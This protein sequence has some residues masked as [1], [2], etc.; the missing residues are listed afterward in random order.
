MLYFRHVASIRTEQI[1]IE[2]RVHLFY[3]AHETRCSSDQD[4]FPCVVFW[5][6]HHDVCWPLPCV[7]QQ[8]PACT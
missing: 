8:H 5:D 4:I 2:M 3:L 6:G 7:C 1:T